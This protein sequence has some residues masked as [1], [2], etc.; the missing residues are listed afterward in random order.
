MMNQSNE[1]KEKINKIQKE[2]DQAIERMFQNG[3]FQRFL[4][5][6]SKFPKYS[7]NNI[8]MIVSQNPDATL[9]MGYK[10]WQELGR[11]VQKGE[12]AIKIFAPLF[13][14]ESLP[15]IDPKTQEPI[16][17]EKGNPVME[18]RETLYGF[19]LVNVFDISQTKGKELFNI[20]KLM[21]EDLK[22]DH[23]IQSLYK[24]FMHYLNKKIEVKEEILE[25][26]NVKGYYNPIK[27]HIRVNASVENTSMKFKILIHEYAHSLLHHKE[28]DMKNL[29][30]GHME[31]QAEAVAFIVSKYYGLD[32]EA[33]SSGYI[34]TW[35]K[36]IK[37]AKQAMKE[38]QH[39]AN[40]V[41]QEI[42]ELMRD[43]MKEISQLHEKSD[44]KEMKT[45]KEKT[46]LSLER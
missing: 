40:G 15:K 24:N 5:V 31:A 34:A 41:I 25:N 44:E 35:S 23:H 6:T 8:I 27:H 29:P 38:I 19:K 13:R 45:S 9:V 26:P 28:S 22:E 30:R 46:S 12:K 14:K 43:R 1:Y 36:D 17:D 18:K 37:L 11:Q 32:T 2:V 4:E 10:K 3:E 42:D 20:H 7:L 33:Y 16:F 21:Q 39:V